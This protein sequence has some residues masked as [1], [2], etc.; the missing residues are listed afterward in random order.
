MSEN[1]LSSS[2][3]NPT[4]GSPGDRSDPA[5]SVEIQQPGKPDVYPDKMLNPFNK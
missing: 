4:T 2:A 5:P 1:Q 3:L